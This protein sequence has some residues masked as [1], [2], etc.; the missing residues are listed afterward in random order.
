MIGQAIADCIGVDALASHN[1]ITKVS[2][3]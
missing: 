1:A 3:K 2:V